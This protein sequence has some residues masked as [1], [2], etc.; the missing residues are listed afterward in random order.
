MNL[1]E[2]FVPPVVPV[3][4]TIPLG[5]QWPPGYLLLFRGNR[6]VFAKFPLKGW[7]RLYRVRP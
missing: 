3:H 1:A 5:A 4:L 6:A 2:Q 7:S